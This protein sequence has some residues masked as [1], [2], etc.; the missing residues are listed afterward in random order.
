VSRV[1]LKVDSELKAVLKELK[2]LKNDI[3]ASKKKLNRRLPPAKI[4][5]KSAKLN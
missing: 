1:E 3:S 2:E 4:S 5:L